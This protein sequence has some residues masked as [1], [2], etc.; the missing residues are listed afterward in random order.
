[1]NIIV[2]VLSSQ[3]IGG[4]R[5]GNRALLGAICSG[6]KLLGKHEKRN[7]WKRQEVTVENV[8]SKLHTED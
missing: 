3:S 4:A 5:Y 7:S 8:I 6:N 2:S 1:M